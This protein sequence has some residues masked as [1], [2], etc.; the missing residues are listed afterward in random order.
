VQPE[1]LERLG[2]FSPALLVDPTNTQCPFEWDK[3]RPLVVAEKRCPPCQSHLKESSDEDDDDDMG[4]G[5]DKLCTTAQ[6][7]LLHVENGSM[8]WVNGKMLHWTCKKCKAN[9]EED[10]NVPPTLITCAQDGLWPVNVFIKQGSA[11]PLLRLAQHDSRHRRDEGGPEA[12]A[13]DLHRR[14]HA[15][16]HLASRTASLGQE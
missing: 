10:C 15:P 5:M 13:H 14:L 8:R 7:C 4:V 16:V 11:L 12:E 6:F 9:M 2:V 3:E 1:V